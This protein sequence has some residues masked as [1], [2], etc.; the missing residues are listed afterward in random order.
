MRGRRKK[1]RKF[2]TFTTKSQIPTADIE[3]EN[4]TVGFNPIDV[5]AT[6]PEG[7]GSAFSYCI[8]CMIDL[9]ESRKSKGCSRTLSLLLLPG[10][11]SY[12]VP[13]EY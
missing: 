9:V 3:L 8:L 13:N 1:A 6:S 10:V 2:V 5:I 7:V 12:L 11:S 4:T